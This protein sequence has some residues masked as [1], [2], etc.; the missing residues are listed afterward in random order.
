M[1]KELAA[2]LLRRYKYCRH[3]RLSLYPIFVVLA[4]LIAKPTIAGIIIGVVFI[5]AGIWTRILASNVLIRA[6]QLTKT[7]I[8]QYL[9]HPLYI[10]TLITFA[11]LVVMSCQWISLGAYA[12]FVALHLI[13]IRLEGKVLWLIFGKDYVTYSKSL[14]T[15]IAGWFL[16]MFTGIGQLKRGIRQE[17][18]GLAGTV[19]SVLLMIA[20]YILLEG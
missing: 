6:H 10:G 2:T 15:P 13:F 20:K 3:I 9:A 16:A 11:G 5:L 19:G 4:L 14:P 12:F 8:Y 18:A 17:V 1:T 7:G